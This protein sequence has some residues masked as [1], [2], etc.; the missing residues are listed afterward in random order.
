NSLFQYLKDVSDEKIDA[1][2][3]RYSY[4]I[5]G[6]SGTFYILSDGTIRQFPNS[7][8]IIARKDDPTESGKHIF[9]ILTPDGVEHTFADRETAKVDI[10]PM[11]LESVPK[12]RHYSYTSSWFLSQSVSSEHADTIRWFYRKLPPVTHSASRQDSVW[13]FTQD[14]RKP[15]ISDF[16]AG[17]YSNSNSSVSGT[18]GT[19]FYDGRVP[20]RIE[21]RTGRIDFISEEMTSSRSNGKRMVIT[22]LKLHDYIG[23]EVSEAFIS[24]TRSL[25]D[26]PVIREIRIERDGTAIDCQRFEYNQ[27]SAMRGADLFGHFNGT[28][29][30]SGDTQHLPYLASG[31]FNPRCYS[32]TSALKWWTI[33]SVSDITGLRTDI[34]YEP[35]ITCRDTTVSVVRGLNPIKPDTGPFITQITG[36]Y[37]GGGSSGNDIYMTVTTVRAIAPALRVKSITSSDPLTGSKKVRKLVYSGEVATV[38]PNEISLDCYRSLSGRYLHFGN[39][40]STTGVKE[41]LVATLSRSH[42]LPGVSVERTAIVHS[43]VSEAITGTG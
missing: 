27:G 16:V 24:Y 2:L 22:G 37:V 28:S 18:S 21:G 4:S 26:E 43:E 39:S 13:T 40:I 7:D 10:V 19:T 32:D 3:D 1:A 35:I 42:R 41:S 20:S 31:R 33:K 36:D 34:E 9:T 25:W 14:V 38:D 30:P 23:T 8:V 17:T 29:M 11:G 5:P 12:E 6:Y 15:S